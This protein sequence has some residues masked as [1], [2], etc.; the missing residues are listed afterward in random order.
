Q[1]WAT[2]EGFNGDKLPAI[3]GFVQRIQAN[4]SG[5]S[6]KRTSVGRVFMGLRIKTAHG[7]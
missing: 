1:N 5:I 6:Y 7:A 2:T 3:N 4:V